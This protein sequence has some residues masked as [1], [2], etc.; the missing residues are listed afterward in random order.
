MRKSRMKFIALSLLSAI[1]ITGIIP[2]VA[3]AEELQVSEETKQ[4]IT[5]SVEEVTNE[6]LDNATEVTSDVTED[7]GE[8]VEN[9]TTE[10]AKE[11]AE[12]EVAVTDSV[13]QLNEVVPNEE[14]V[15]STS[16]SL[17]INSTDDMTFSDET[18]VSAV[19][20]D[21]YYVV[22]YDTA[23]NAKI[24]FDAF[25]SQGIA[26]EY[27]NSID[28]PEDV[29][30]SELD[31]VE[32]TS[33]EVE[34]TEADTEKKTITV[35]VLDTGIADI[36]DDELLKDMVLEG[37]SVI[38]D[39]V[40]D[41]NGHGTVMANI[42]ASS[43]RDTEMYSDTEI[44]ILP[45][46]VL[47]EN[48]NGSVLSVY[49]G[50]EYALSHNADVIN[51]SIS[52]LG[53]SNILT[54]EINKAY[55]QGVTTVVAAGNNSD[56]V[57]NYIPGNIDTAITVSAVADRDSEKVF[58]EY[59][60][61][62][63]FVDF[64]AMGTYE[65]TYTDEAGEEIITSV[66]GTSVASAY[67]TSYVAMLKALG[68]EDVSE[69]DVYASLQASVEDLGEA[70][71]D[72][73]FGFG[74]LE[75]ENI[76][77]IKAAS[78]ID[79]HKTDNLDITEEEWANAKDR[80]LTTAYSL[81]CGDPNKEK[82][83]IWDANT[84]STGI[85][86]S[87]YS[88]GNNNFWA[89]NA[90]FTWGELQ[91]TWGLPAQRKDSRIS[92]SNC[93]G[94]ALKFFLSLPNDYDIYLAWN[95]S[96]L[97][98]DGCY[99]VNGR[100]VV[101][102][103]DAVAHA[104]RGAGCVDCSY[105][106][107]YGFVN[108]G[109]VVPN[110]AS[111]TQFGGAI[112]GPQLGNGCTATSIYIENGGYC[113]LKD[114]VVTGTEFG[115]IN[116]GKLDLNNTTIESCNK[117]IQEETTG[118]MNIIYSRINAGVVGINILNNV[119]NSQGFGTNNTIFGGSYGVDNAA[120]ILV[121]NNTSTVSSN[122]TGLRM[123]N[124]YFYQNGGSIYG[125]SQGIDV[126][127]N[128]Y[129][130]LDGG[131]AHSSG[132]FLASAVHCHS[133][134]R[135]FISGG[136][137]SGFFGVNANDTGTAYFCESFNADTYG[138]NNRDVVN[139][140][141]NNGFLWFLHYLQH[142][143]RE[144]RV[145]G[146]GKCN[147]VISGC[148]IGIQIG[149]GA[150]SRSLGRFSNGIQSAPTVTNCEFGVRADNAVV[151]W[152][153]TQSGII[154]NC[155]NGVVCGNGGTFNFWSGISI[156]N[157]VG[158]LAETNGKLNIYN[159]SIS[160]D[161]NP[162][163]KAMQIGVKNITN[164]TTAIFN[165]TSIYN[166]SDKGIFNESGTVTI[167]RNAAINIYQNQTGIW[168]QAT[169]N[170]LGGSYWTGSDTIGGIRSNTGQGIV[171]Y[172]SLTLSPDPANNKRIDIAQNGYNGIY[173]EGVVS[174]NGAY[175]W[176]NNHAG[177]V[178]GADGTTNPTYIKTSGNFDNN[179]YEGL[180]NRGNANVLNSNIYNNGS[181]GVVNYK[182]ATI[183]NST[184]YNNG[185]KSGWAVAGVCN[186][187]TITLTNDTIRNNRFINA[188]NNVGTMTINGG[189]NF[190]NGS[191]QTTNFGVWN[192]DTLNINS[193]SFYGFTTDRGT[194]G[195]SCLW[196]CKTA[197]V[198]GGNFN[199][200]HYGLV[201]WSTLNQSGGSSNS[202]SV[203]D[204]YQGGDYNV[205]PVSATI[206]INKVFV[207]PNKVINFTNGA[208][209][210]RL[211][212]NMNLYLDTNDRVV[213]RIL[214]TGLENEKYKE[215]NAQG[216][217]FYKHI[218]V[219]TP[220]FYD[221][222]DLSLN[223]N[224]NTIKENK[225]TH[226]MTY[227]HLHKY[228]NSFVTTAFYGLYHKVT[229]PAGYET[230][231]YVN[232]KEQDYQEYFWNE[233]H[234]FDQ[235]EVEVKF[236][237]QGKEDDSMVLFGWRDK[238]GVIYYPDGSVN[239]SLSTGDKNN[240]RYE[241][242]TAILIPSRIAVKYTPNG[243]NGEDVI[244]KNIVTTKTNGKVVTSGSY[245]TLSA[246][247]LGYI[248]DEKVTDIVDHFGKVEKLSY[249]SVGFDRDITKN[250]KNLDFKEKTDYEN[251]IVKVWLKENGDLSEYA[252]ESYFDESVNAYVVTL[253]TIWDEAPTV[254]TDTVIVPKENID[255]VT[256][257]YLIEQA[258]TSLTDDN[259]E[260][261]TGIEDGTI[262]VHIEDF[263]L[264]EIKNTGNVGA[265]SEV[266]VATDCVGNETRSMFLLV[267]TSTSETG[268]RRFTRKIN[269]ENYNKRDTSLPDGG[270]SLGAM[271]VNSEWY[272]DENK[273]NEI[274]E[275]FYNLK[276]DRYIYKW[277]FDIDGMRASKE[278][279]KKYKNCP[280]LVWDEEVS[281]FDYS[282]ISEHFKESYLYQYR[283]AMEATGHVK[284]FDK[285][286]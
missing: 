80:L 20:Y 24:A 82:W 7:V 63:S 231:V 49:M 116:N 244:D 188:W 59:S 103:V 255:T 123:Q 70:G 77:E 122:G 164:A 15:S 282:Y 41:N 245:T 52:G 147:A 178:N 96:S 146:N 274:K 247:E 94:L 258:I 276:N 166:C 237:K 182:T 157:T 118:E 217:I 22:T 100:K 281:H 144:E 250:Y 89:P 117:G 61:H 60:N 53:N 47:D 202:N 45:I 271:A 233:N 278:Y 226:V 1:T 40:Y 223:I 69:T 68:R 139:A 57:A 114:V 142:G 86:Y 277:H 4:E 23:D 76:K 224:S 38:D 204:V 160:C 284:V 143:I 105:S 256:E 165:T 87:Y 44:K 219:A 177:V 220:A 108:T 2:S 227:N 109:L 151:N 43:F 176:G 149:N 50:M 239:K 136:D 39:S 145:A 232:G 97:D 161:Y 27:N 78:N 197:N 212:G 162:N 135:A 222:K 249:K 32:N 129:I 124:G 104:G 133:G 121:S 214:V 243:A 266:L 88:P 234:S 240:A 95:A 195:A 141:G 238:N 273:A 174:D 18:I 152:N 201:N 99:V 71:F 183:S 13:E 101:Y 130:I 267:K 280:N 140:F 85:R 159:T 10:P 55:N 180:V 134:G 48:G 6:L 42:I 175:I 169:C 189:S 192:N 102:C 252:K 33:D 14:L 241:E 215:I 5:T 203:Y 113:N 206:T 150:T 242:L 115:I 36:S 3:M 213:G 207:C 235:N 191:E 200:S 31:K 196:N 172:G 110:G 193:G 90:T 254:A 25:T 229:A 107:Y 286:Y 17:I 19:K 131:S 283:N 218:W 170:I 251:F 16:T 257:Q 261:K 262:K 186:G 158:C 34:S 128:A 127:G 264:D 9:V 269:E 181:N 62:G 270:E 132:N 198:R 8:V 93:M 167:D 66:N 185:I 155:S 46:K 72:E 211:L 221:N 30:K 156:D 37:Y 285:N 216:N 194:D 210:T 279:M 268:G 171:N 56:D 253:N 209:G 125:A 29:N 246:D 225:A 65:M 11:V 73:Y 84:S 28:K 179:G 259:D 26:V 248:H 58:A 138:A 208:D 205:S 98:G 228:N 83:V 54:N 154:Y 148:T 126:I 79:Q 236:F 21:E 230:K 111:Y 163:C 75:K 190:N 187:G 120:N 35:A 173:N 51:L 272:L 184:I 106:N 64:S 137:I 260:F 153:P 74:Y 112:Y 275:A 168:N 263:D 81:M 119:S 199:N 265:V 67:V 91:S 92:G 12:K